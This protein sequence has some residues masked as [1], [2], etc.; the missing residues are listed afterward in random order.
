MPGFSGSNPDK[1]IKEFRQ[2]IAS[3]LNSTVTDA[4]VSEVIME[5]SPIRWEAR[6]SLGGKTGDPR[7]IPLKP[8]PWHLALSQKIAVVRDRRRNW[9]LR[10]LQYSYRIQGGPDLRSGWY[11]R[12]EY[13]S[14]EV[15]SAL[16]PRSHLHLPV[17][18]DC[19]TRRMDLSRVHIPTGPVTLEEIIRFLIQELGV[20]AKAKDWDSALRISEKKFWTWTSTSDGRP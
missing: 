7:A 4:P 9:S 5:K 18:L 10:T 1:I 15:L 13:K 16:H 8:A 6:I 19:G 11:F 17:S 2:Y 14:R 3:L 12:F 20:K